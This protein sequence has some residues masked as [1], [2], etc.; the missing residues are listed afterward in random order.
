MSEISKI[1]LPVL[2][3]YDYEEMHV[4]NYLSE[5]VNVKG[6]GAMDT[7]VSQATEAD[8]ANEFARCMLHSN[9][10]MAD[11]GIM[12]YDGRKYVSV[13][14]DK[15]VRLIQLVLK[16]NGCGN[17]YV[18]RSAET[19]YKF[20]T[21][22]LG[23][24]PFTPSKNIV[25][26]RNCVV[27]LDDMMIMP[28]GEF[29]QSVT[30]IDIDYDKKAKC[31][32]FRQFLT[33]VLPDEDTQ[34]VL[35]EFIGCM[36]VDRTKIKIEK[37]LY[38]LGAGRNGKSVIMNIIAKIAGDDNISR[39]SLHKLLKGS[40]SDYNI[41]Q[42][43][44]KL[45][46]LCNDMGNE[47]ISGGEFKSYIS[48]EPLM[49]RL[50]FGKPFMA[51][52]PPIVI[53]AM[54]QLPQS[55]DHTRGATERPIIIPFN[56]YITDDMMDT[57][58]EP[59]LFEELSGIFNW[60]AEGRTRFIK[61]GG[62]FTKSVV[63]EDA[64]KDAKDNSNSLM[65]FLADNRY[66]PRMM[67]GYAYKEMTLKEFYRLYCIFVDENGGNKFSHSNCGRILS[68]EGYE[69]RRTANGQMYGFYEKPFTVELNTE[70]QRMQEVQ[71]TLPF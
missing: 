31:D 11:S 52:N 54:N 65:R 19:I 58:L 41:A 4:L 27:N 13:D 32:R 8:M 20:A 22:M 9:F 57:S 23:I 40:T 37:V 30:Y 63:V 39:H 70:E 68:Q 44:K 15:M 18:V 5:S 10:R 36:F 47:D 59:K 50:P 33:E 28:H 38:L 45:V 69:K 64:K 48:G 55:T 67:E 24:K 29:H 61:Q 17:C 46:N 42:A 56:T 3:K 35:Q 34:K 14:K 25:S 71:S 49:A 16:L 62:K 26:F 43:D 12:V 66:Y 6:L 53:A 7:K 21:S 1:G 51:S 2:K 60:I